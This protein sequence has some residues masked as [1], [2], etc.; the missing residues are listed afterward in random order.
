[1][2]VR[3]R[4]LLSL[5]FL[6]TG[7][8]IGAAA[9]VSSSPEP[10][11]VDGW[12]QA[13]LG[14]SS[15]TDKWW[16]GGSGWGAGAV[17]GQA[18]TTGDKPVQLAALTFRICET[19]QS[20]PTK[21]YNIRIGQVDGQVLTPL[22]EEEAEQ[23][24]PFVPGGY[25][26]W[27]LD[28]P[29]PLQPRT[30]YAVDVDMLSSTSPWQTGIPY[31][32]RFPMD[33]IPGGEAYQAMGEG[34][35]TVKL[36][37]GDRVFHLDLAAA[38]GSSAPLSLAPVAG[39]G[40]KRVAVAGDGL[41]ADPEFSALLQ[42][43][44]GRG[45]EVRAFGAEGASALADLPSVWSKSTAARDLAA[46]APQVILLHLGVSDTQADRRARLERWGENYQQVVIS[47][48][49]LRGVQ[50]LWLCV[51]RFA[52]ADRASGADPAFFAANLEV[53]LR[54]AAV[55][56]GASALDLPPDPAKLP[57]AA[58]TVQVAAWRMAEAVLGRTP[59]P[60]ALSAPAPVAVAP[61]ASPPAAAARPSAP[62]ASPPPP[63]PT[64]RPGPTA[65]AAPPTPPSPVR[66][67][68]LG[69]GLDSALS[70]TAELGRLLG[71]GYEV[72][73]FQVGEARLLHAAGVP[74]SR[75][76]RL[77]EARAD[78]PQ[79]VVITLADDPDEESTA[80]EVTAF[81]RDL[82]QILNELNAWNP[83]PVVVLANPAP[84]H[85]V[86]PPVGRGAPKPEA[87][88]EDKRKSGAE[89]VVE[90]ARAAFR[91]AAA[92]PG[93]VHDDE[94]LVPKDAK[95]VPQV[96]LAYA[97]HLAEAVRAVKVP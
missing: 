9:T 39:G 27:K 71:A 54:L 82:R 57:A 85:V 20:A 10:S 83:R 28:H 86:P 49:Q 37:G 55:E 81:D 64:V 33:K 65:P 50:A 18:F 5:W 30:R 53:P 24:E 3:S 52:P 23:T 72:N 31:L 25:V 13:V 14:S 66:V 7:L 45:F 60:A 17:M 92:D 68:C 87:K 8:R 4:R 67:A 59:D 90:R 36:S 1:M 69:D 38:D 29:F 21:V 51:P 44:L 16:L 43:L 73:S 70:T 46:F 88:R 22:Y 32:Q 26:T 12:D 78:K 77:A 75:S 97:R 80:R 93:R 47:L 89:T 56:T 62:P 95:G 58:T 79:V 61:P 42:R 35:T 96:G 34:Y 76:G 91:L 41:A 19:C 6:T 84:F 2:R 74:Y 40:G 15:V 48:M 11:P 94:A 63:A